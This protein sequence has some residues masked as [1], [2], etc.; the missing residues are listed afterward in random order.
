MVFRPTEDGRVIFAVPWNGRLLV[1]TTDT[2][3]TPGE[4]MVVT[5]EEI[6][7]LLRQLNQYL[8]TPLTADQMVS[9]YAG[10]R[11]LVSAAGVKETKKLIRDDEVEF[12][13]DS[14]MVSILGGKWTTHRLM[15]E[16]TIDK[17]QEYLGGPAVPTKTPEHQL[18]GSADYS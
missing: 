17:V 3:Y 13:A 14:G 7:Y 16:E 15:G 4:E 2:G 1:G 5:R 11:P 9:G 18:N 12:D 10:I 8:S 6:D